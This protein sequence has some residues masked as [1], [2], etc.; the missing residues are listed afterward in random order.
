MNELE[1]KLMSSNLINDEF[2]LDK[3]IYDLDIEIE[4]KY[5]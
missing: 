2:N 3:I 5:L 1:I 4:K